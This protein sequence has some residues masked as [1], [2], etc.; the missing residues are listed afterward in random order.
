MADKD[1]YRELFEMY[2]PFKVEMLADSM[3]E[4]MRAQF[5]PEEAALAIKV[6][7]AGGKLDEIQ[8]R[9]GIEKAK[10]RGMLESMAKKG[11][12]WIDPGTDDPRYRTI[13]FGGPG[14]IETGG[15]GNIKFPNSVQIMKA[16]HGLEVEV[17]KKWLPALGTPVTR[18]WLTPAAVPEDARPTENL[19]EMVKRAGQWG[20]STCSCRL[21]HWIA[22]PGNH[23][24]NPLET[25][26]FMGEMVRWGLEQNMCR[27]IS[28]EEAMDTLRECN[29]A[30]MVHTHDPAEFVC[31]CCDDCCVFF[32]GIKEAGAKPLYP[33]EFIPVV[34]ELGCDACC[35]CEDRCPV[36]AIEVEDIATVDLDKCL[37]CGVCFPTC[38]TESIEFARRP[39]TETLAVHDHENQHLI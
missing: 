4:L 26:M 34:D 5:T 38:P 2:A 13:G 11:T 32:V 9:T 1:I 15:W 30:G 18:V 27:E 7:F 33:S 16:L 21:P 12:M 28:Y 36:D 19:A 8:E 20:I 29:E 37:G 39:G 23:C 31:N 17:G 22:D 3:T 25:C 14:L 24:T 35:L 10:L 6:G